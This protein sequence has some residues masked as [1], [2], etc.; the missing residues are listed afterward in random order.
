MRM[1]DATV[2]F[3]RVGKTFQRI[4]NETLIL[5]SLRTNVSRCFYVCLLSVISTLLRRFSKS[6]VISTCLISRDVSYM[7]FVHNLIMGSSRQFFDTRREIS[8]T[9]VIFPVQCSG[10]VQILNFFCASI[11]KIEQN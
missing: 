4:L 7:L 9:N 5:Q 6:V 1:C 3:C 11:I 10:L 2:E 8:S